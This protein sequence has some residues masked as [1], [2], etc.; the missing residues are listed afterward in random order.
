MEQVVGEAAD[1]FLEQLDALRHAHLGELFR[2][3]A[4]QRPAGLVQRV[5]LL[6]LFDGVGH[7]AG[8]DEQHRPGAGGLLQ[9]RDV[10]VDEA[11]AAADETGGD[12]QRRGAGLALNGADGEGG[13]KRAVL[14]PEQLR[15]AEGLVKAAADDIAAAPGLE[16]GVG[17]ADLEVEIDQGDAF[18][19]G[20]EDAL[21]QQE[22]A[23]RFQKRRVG[24]TAENGVEALLAEPLQGGGDGIDRHGL[25]LR[26]TAQPLRGRRAGF[27]KDQDARSVRHGDAA[28]GADRGLR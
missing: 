26:P 27:T 22:A 2:R 24:G 5:E 11:V 13:V 7:V 25:G 20:V 15:R 10:Q 1:V 4:G 19:H 17:P 8:Q 12:G 28:L 18:R 16:G 9:R 23:R 14:R 21:R 3:E 6:P